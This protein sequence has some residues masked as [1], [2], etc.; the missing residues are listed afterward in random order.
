MQVFVALSVVLSLAFAD[1]APSY[2]APVP[3]YAPASSYKE[4]SY[5]GP[6]SYN[7]G[8]A[9]EDG[10]AGVNFGANEARDGHA[11]NGQYNVLLPDGRTQTVT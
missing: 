8:Y 6:V 1:H 7:I 10:Y 9:V 11:T 2:G 5:D 4:P 3:S